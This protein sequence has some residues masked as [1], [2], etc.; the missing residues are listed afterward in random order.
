MAPLVADQI[1]CFDGGVEAFL[2]GIF[3]GGI[4]GAV[5][6]EKT[7]LIKPSRMSQRLIGPTLRLRF[8]GRYSFAM[9]A[10]NCMSQCP[11]ISMS[12]YLNVPILA[13]VL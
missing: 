10:W 6:Y 2:R 8:A 9:G 11:N 7:D 13:S 5:F 3:A 12:Q 1:A 4:L